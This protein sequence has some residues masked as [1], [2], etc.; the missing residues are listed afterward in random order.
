M[1]PKTEFSR[2]MILDAG[3]KIVREQGWEQLSARAI[4]NV[5][6][7]STRPV[8]SSFS[9]MQEIKDLLGR[10]VN[11]ML[12]DYQFRAN[13]GKPFLDMGV[14]Y[15]LFARDEP[16]LFRLFYL[17]HICS[18]DMEREMRITAKARLLD[19]MKDD[20]EVPKL[21]DERTAKLLLNLKIFTHGLACYITAGTYEFGEEEIVSLIK[22]AGNAFFRDEMNESGAESEHTDC[23][24]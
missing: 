15:V 14:G 24:H 10:Q 20:P 8:Y 18:F 3:L 17:P 21:N 4:A 2:E 7:C 1:P 5:L 11:E 22:E 12:V 6:Q 19:K 16:E 9:S 13:T 23:R